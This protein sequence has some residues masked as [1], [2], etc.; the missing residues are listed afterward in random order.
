MGKRLKTSPSQ[1]KKA[2]STTCSAKSKAITKT[3]TPKKGFTTA[4]KG[5][6]EDKDTD[7]DTKAK[8]AYRTTVVSGTFIKQVASFTNVQ[9]K[10]AK[11]ITEISN[12][13]DVI[14][15]SLF[16]DLRQTTPIN[17]TIEPVDIANSFRRVC[18]LP[19]V[20]Q[21]YQT[22]YRRLLGTKKQLNEA[23]HRGLTE[24]STTNTDQR[25]LH[26]AFWSE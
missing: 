3:K 20:T 4:T 22:S 18:N 25:I 24:P 7:H 26:T 8:K 1:S 5:A 15:S 12:V 14:A 9:F 6:A 16:E 21:L 13:C 19:I 23:F 2:P 10:H 11:S 17:S